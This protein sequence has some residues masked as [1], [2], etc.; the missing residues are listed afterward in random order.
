MLQIVNRNH[1]SVFRLCSV[2][3]ASN[4]NESYIKERK[5][6]FYAIS[7]NNYNHSHNLAYCCLYTSILMINFS[8]L[9][10]YLILPSKMH[11]FIYFYSDKILHSIC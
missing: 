8:F 9:D 6:C 5:N 4:L 11:L 10:I 3:L 1:P 7:N 2:L